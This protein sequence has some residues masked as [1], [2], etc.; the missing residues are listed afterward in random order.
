MSIIE[1]GM[2]NIKSKIG[3]KRVTIIAIK[4]SS[5]LES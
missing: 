1:E 5:I 2:I 3:Y 4:S